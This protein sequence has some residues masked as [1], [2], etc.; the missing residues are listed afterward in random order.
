MDIYTIILP[1]YNDWESLS[2][3][4]V[5]IEKNLKNTKK[6]YKVLIINDN[7][8]EKNIYKLNKN[9]FFKEI[10]IINLKKNVGSQKAIATGLKFINKYKNK[11]ENKFIIMDSDGEDNPKKIKEIIKLIDKNNNTEIITMNRTLRKESFFF[12]ILYEVHLLITFLITLKYI[13]FG[14]FSFLNRNVINK[15]T[16]K[17]ELWLAYSATLNKYFNSKTTITAPRQKRISGKSK[18]SYSSLIVH[19]LNIQSVYL[20]NIFLSYFFYSSVFLFLYVF[21]FF[22]IIALVLFF[23]LI[24]HF[25]IIIF[26]VKKKINGITFNL[27]LN[28]IRSIKKI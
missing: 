27:C 21:K 10:K 1:T 6:I 9:K 23:L 3:L 18:M 15:I 26:S 7:S 8:S 5:Q 16:K 24:G 20:K 28:N 25:C 12:S 4:L 19:S 17:K 22:E 11:K 14:N 13:R 2:V